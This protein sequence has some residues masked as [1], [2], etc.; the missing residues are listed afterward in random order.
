MEKV[1]G[2][3]LVCFGEFGLGICLW[4]SLSLCVRKRCLFVWVPPFWFRG[5]L[6]CRCCVPAVV[7]PSCRL[8]LARCCRLP[9]LRSLGFVMSAVVVS[10]SVCS[11]SA[12]FGASVR[13]LSR[14]SWCPVTVSVCPW[15]GV[16]SL[17]AELVGAAVPVWPAIRSLAWVDGSS[18][19]DADDLFVADVG[20]DERVNSRYLALE[21]LMHAVGI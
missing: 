10:V 19:G 15:T 4:V 6:S 17:S 20:L 9:C 7:P 5:P 3:P 2:V 11:H 14:L 18:S 8:C 16:A 13:L 21:S 1:F 12:G